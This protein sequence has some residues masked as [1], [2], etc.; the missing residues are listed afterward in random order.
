MLQT[1]KSCVGCKI[2][3]E[4][5]P[6][7]LLFFKN[8]KTQFIIRFLFAQ[9]FPPEG[10]VSSLSRSVEE[11]RTWNN[12]RNN[13]YRFINNKMSPKFKKILTICR[14]LGQ[15]YCYRFESTEYY[16][17]DDTFLGHIMLYVLR[18]TFRLFLATIGEYNF[19]FFI[20]SCF[21]IKIRCT[22][23]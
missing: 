3:L 4:K 23:Q 6:M 18:H 8:D 12:W 11:Y 2:Q 15:G 16:S 14:S 21:H 10:H 17:D 1:L 9:T 22:I 5:H 13:F 20:T 7:F 19:K